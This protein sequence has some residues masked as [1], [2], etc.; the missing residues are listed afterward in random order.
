MRYFIAAEGGGTSVQ[1]ILYDE[2]CRMIRKARTHGVNEY[3]KSQS[4][5]HQ[6][7]QNLVDDLIPAEITEIE[8][9]D[10]CLVTQTNILQEIISRRCHVKKMMRWNEGECAL[11]AAGVRWGVAAQAGTGSDA[12]YIQPDQEDLVGGWGSLLG[13]EGSG[14]DL[15]LQSLKAAIWASEGRGPE[16][17]LQPLICNAWG[18]EKMRDIIGKMKECP[19]QRRMIAQTTYLTAQAAQQG[20]AVALSLYERAGHDMAHQVVTLLRRYDQWIGPVVASG[21][22][23]KGCGRMFDVFRQD[24]LASFPHIQVVRPVFEPIIGVI[25]LGLMDRRWNMDEAK[26]I[27]SIRFKEF[28]MR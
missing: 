19:D 23:W 21:G 3:F 16:T 1:A 9:V 25:F 22:A 13:D 5:I 4:L 24:I 10:W 20:D 14:Y 18:L 28:L 7:M 27:L 12:F 15:G 6:E 11:A 2:H 8:R 17:L 26:E